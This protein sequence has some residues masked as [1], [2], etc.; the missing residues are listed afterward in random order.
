MDKINLYYKDGKSDKVYHAQIVEKDGGYIVP[1]QY[2]RRGTTLATGEK[3]K[4]PVTLEKAQSILASLYKEKTGKGYTEG[5]DGAVFQSKS[6]E[7]RFTGNV[8]QLLNAFPK[9]EKK[10]EAL[11]IELLNDD[12][13]VMQEKHDG[14]RTMIQKELTG[15]SASNKKGLS[16]AIP[17][18]VADKFNHLS[19]EALFDGELIGEEYHIFDLL[20]LNG[21]NVR[22]KSVIERLEMLK[23]LEVSSMVTPT[24]YTSNAKSQK[25]EELKR[26]KKTKREGVVFKKKDAKYVPGRPASGGN[27][28]KYKFMEEST[29]VVLSHNDTKRSIGVGVYDENKNMIPLGNVTIYAN[30]DIPAI[31]AIVEIRY[32]HCFEGGS[33]YVSSLKCERPDQD[34]SD[35]ILSQIKFK[36]KNDDDDNDE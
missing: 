23:N 2:G 34:E 16:V 33:I 18:S 7:E 22:D 29:M 8:P 30:Q 6:L 5:E 31:G 1:F 32:M 15:V 20:M 27:Q 3:T 4:E 9:D 14:W 11:L 17:Q 19:V 25:F 36:T 10:R 12:D 35:C 26:D 24:Y 21:K 13:W 28:R